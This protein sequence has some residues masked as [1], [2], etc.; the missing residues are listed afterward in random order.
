MLLVFKRKCPTTARATYSLTTCLAFMLRRCVMAM[1]RCA[2]DPV[3]AET[4]LASILRDV[5][6]D[7]NGH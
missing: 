2:D 3:M 1:V 7:C 6:A 5:K 4:A